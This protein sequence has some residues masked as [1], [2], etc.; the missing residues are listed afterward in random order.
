MN[1]TLHLLAGIAVVSGCHKGVVH[2]DEISPD[3]V[4][5]AN[6]TAQQ[7][8]NNRTLE[9]DDY[10]EHTKAVFNV[11]VGN[12]PV[13]GNPNALVT[14]VEFADFQCA[15]CSSVEPTLKALRGKYGNR[16]R[17]VWK[18]DPPSFHPAAEPAAEAVLEVR[19][20][21]GAEGFWN[22][23]DRLFERQEAL[24][25]G[26]TPDIGAIVKIAGEAGGNPDKVEKAIAR[27]THQEEI[28]ADLELGEDLE[29]KGTLHFFINGRRLDGAQ[30]RERFEKMIEEELQTAQSAIAK[31]VP[32]KELYETLIKKGRGPWPTEVKQVPKSLPTNTPAIGSPTAKVTIHVWS[33]YQCAL[34]VAAERTMS[35]LRKDFGDRI[36]F[37]WHDLPLP[38]HADAQMVAQAGREAY[39]QKSSSGFWAVHDKI[40]SHPQRVTR[41]DLDAFAKDLNLDMN[42]WKLAL[43]GGTHSR[44]IEADEKAAADDGITETPAYL[45]VPLA[46]PQGYF[47]NAMQEMS[48][49]RRIVQ[50][51]IDEAG[52]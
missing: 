15:P 14:I 28:D 21:R 9:G 27:R 8:E 40:M 19:A 4:A 34:C 1:A 29:N 20:E 33:D 38:R 43:D 47:V 25:A 22:M 18:N 50:R 30:P 46:S 31:G 5:L 45:V 42:R 24:I 7:N 17:M 23:H 16:I 2:R 48:R 26:N 12:S 41:A 10:W 36:K 51:A 39:V 37:V 3:A 44:E 13:L 32:L 52:K 35:Q 49:L 11:P 6:E